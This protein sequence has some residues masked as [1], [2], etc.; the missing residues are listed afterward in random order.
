[1]AKD[2][3]PQK[4]Q[5]VFIHGIGS[6]LA[7]WCYVMLILSA[8]GYGVA[9]LDLP[10]HGKNPELPFT[11]N[12]M[13]FFELSKAWFEMQDFNSFVLVSNSLGGA[14]SIEY[15][16][17]Y[18]QKLR[19]LIM[20][21]PLSGFDSEKEWQEFKPLILL[22]SRSQALRFAQKVYHKPPKI[23]FWIAG[24]IRKDFNRRGVLHLIETATANDLN[25]I[26]DRKELSVKTLVI[27]G[28]SDHFFGSK[29]LMRHKKTLPN[30]VLYEEPEGIGHC[31]QL[32]RP[33]WVANRIQNFIEAND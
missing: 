21:S 25:G 17:N 26:A 2:G 13:K 6:N 33:R 15:A 1:M 29:M 11:L 8:K 20:I 5:I 22:K 28:K 30:H 14:L 19:N 10:G 31:P 3:D 7:H 32:E 16:L 23:L 24:D 9:A 4:P 12:S 18:P 27:W